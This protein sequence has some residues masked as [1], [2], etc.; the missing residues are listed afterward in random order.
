[1]DD[2]SKTLWRAA[3]TALLVE[4]QAEAAKRP[5]PEVM[6]K[7]MARLRAWTALEKHRRKMLT[8]T[9]GDK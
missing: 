3:D 9:V 1:M 4:V 5:A 8:A 6:Q 7:A 2:V